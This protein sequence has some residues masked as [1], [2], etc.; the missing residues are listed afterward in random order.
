MIIEENIENESGEDLK[1]DWRKEFKVN[2][3]TLFC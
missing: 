2:E 1:I 3:R